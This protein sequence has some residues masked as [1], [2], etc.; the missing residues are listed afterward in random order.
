M[1][2]SKCAIIVSSF[3]IVSSCKAK[4][5]Q[6]R[7]DRTKLLGFSSNAKE[8]FQL[9]NTPAAGKEALKR[10]FA[11]VDSV[12]AGLGLTAG[13]DSTNGLRENTRVCISS[14]YG[15]AERNSD[16]KPGYVPEAA[17]I[18]GLA[19]LCSTMAGSQGR[20]SWAEGELCLV[21]DCIPKTSN[22][23]DMP[24]QLSDG[25]NGSIC[26]T[27]TGRSTTFS[28]TEYFALANRTSLGLANQNPKSNQPGM[29]LA[30]A[31][32]TSPS[33]VLADAIYNASPDGTVGEASVSLG[34]EAL[35]NGRA[36]SV[37]YS[38]KSVL[39]LNQPIVS[40]DF[41]VTYPA[42][43]DGPTML[44]FSEQG[45][46]P[47]PS[48]LPSSQNGGSIPGSSPTELTHP[49]APSAKSLGLV[50]TR[51]GNRFQLS[52]EGTGAGLYGAAGSV[53]VFVGE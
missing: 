33:E 38:T 39:G 35:F 50:E 34:G 52:D 40:A 14:S 3:I 51:R 9:A 27:S 46:T 22:G 1:T 23:L 28:L 16:G 2:I 8:T 10:G 24:G 6:G 25:T 18:C 49:G 42:K 30:E 48:S 32:E 37:S 26:D 29:A 7:Y 20:L 53:Q 19:K 47:S 21:A 36:M 17:V 43:A 4:P 5:Y 31:T 41:Q 45:S 44:M 13:S 12:G 11:P 15:A